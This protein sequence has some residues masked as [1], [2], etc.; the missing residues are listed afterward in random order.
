M[1]TVTV[2]A[3]PITKQGFPEEAE[4]IEVIRDQGKLQFCKVKMI[5]TG[6]ICNVLINTK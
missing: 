2:Y 6:R 5:E 4:V 3:N 1:K